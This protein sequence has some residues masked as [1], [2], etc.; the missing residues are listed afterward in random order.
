MSYITFYTESVLF[1]NKT[2]TSEEMKELTEF[3]LKEV[4]QH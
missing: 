1:A 4:R 2:E 3:S